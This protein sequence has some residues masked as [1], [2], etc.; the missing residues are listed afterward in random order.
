[1]RSCLCP[2]DYFGAITA[3][4]DTCKTRQP[5]RRG[6]DENEAGF[7]TEFTTSSP[8]WRRRE[9]ET[10]CRTAVIG[11]SLTEYNT[12]GGGNV[13]RLPLVNSAGP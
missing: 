4:K 3:A 7:R 1:M 11:T 8:S 13:F 5:Q 2:F 12:V 10:Y 9:V 6:S